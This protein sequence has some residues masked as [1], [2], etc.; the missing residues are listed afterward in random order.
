MEQIH[1][2]PTDLPVFVVTNTTQHDQLLANFIQGVQFLEYQ[3][4]VL[5]SPEA[6]SPPM[7][8]TLTQNLLNIAKPLTSFLEFLMSL[9][10]PV[11]G[12]KSQRLQYLKNTWLRNPIADLRIYCHRYSLAVLKISFDLDKHVKGFQQSIQRNDREFIDHLEEFE[13]PRNVKVNT[14]TESFHSDTSMQS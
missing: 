1:P 8:S 6:Y 10:P 3:F 12:P 7:L 2:V 11:Y 9:Q 13:G 4:E 5:G 14:P